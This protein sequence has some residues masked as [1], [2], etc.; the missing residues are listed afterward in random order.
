MEID[1][2]KLFKN[3]GIEGALI[4]LGVL[5]LLFSIYNKYILGIKLGFLFLS[6]GMIFRFYNLSIVRGIFNNYLDKF[7]QKRKTLVYDEKKYIY[8]KTEEY[9]T[10]FEKTKYFQFIDFILCLILLS[11]FAFFFLLLI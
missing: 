10:P 4:I 8:N 2:E 6:F 11:I 3:L 1:F 9:S 5:S 7:K